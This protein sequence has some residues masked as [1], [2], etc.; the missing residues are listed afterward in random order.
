[1]EAELSSYGL[2]R[3]RLY[4]VR[5][6]ATRYTVKVGIS[7]TLPEPGAPDQGFGCESDIDIEQNKRLDADHRKANPV[8]MECRAAHTIPRCRG[9]LSRLQVE[10][11]LSR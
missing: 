7:R 3:G 2:N 4:E 5:V 8:A 11:P 10:V 9:N 1:M 6:S